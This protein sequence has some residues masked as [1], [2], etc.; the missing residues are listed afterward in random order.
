[1]RALSRLSDYYR[2]NYLYESHRL[3]LPEFRE[4]VV[5]TC[6]GCRFFVRIAGRTEKRAGCAAAL[7]RY[8]GTGRRVPEEI[9]LAEVIREV[10]K[11]GLARVLAAAP[12]KQACGLFG[13]R[14]GAKG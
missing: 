5:N 6:A 10:G 2:Q 13:P 4:K 12:E 1:M 14:P 7:P 11:D 9:P 3:L 8:A